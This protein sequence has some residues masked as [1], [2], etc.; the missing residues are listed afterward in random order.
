MLLGY[1]LPEYNELGYNYRMTDI[2]AAMGIAQLAKME[3]IT[4]TRR[5]KAD[6]Y[7]K[8]LEKVDFINPPFIP[9]NYYSTYQSF[10]CMIDNEKLGLSIED[11][12][13]FRNNLM[14]KLE[15]IKISTRVGT[16]AVHMLGVYKARYGFND[17]DFPGA[18]KADQLSITLPLYVQMTDED[19]EYV[20]ENIIKIKK[21]LM[22]N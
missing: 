21:E 15:A 11:A 18:Y 14:E 4:S 6:L 2:Q 5:K 13:K 19:Q 16:H 22:V 10:V 8:L 17:K 1:L 12:N 3:Y 9:D 20:I 7:R